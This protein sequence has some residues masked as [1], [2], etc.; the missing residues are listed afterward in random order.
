MEDLIPDENYGQCFHCG[1][2]II[3]ERENFNFCSD[4]CEIENYLY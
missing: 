3:D 4:K 2:P 1:K